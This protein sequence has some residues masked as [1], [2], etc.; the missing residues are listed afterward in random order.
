M[1]E[2]AEFQP[3]WKSPLFWIV[4]IIS[5]L[6]TAS[7][8]IVFGFRRPPKSGPETAPLAPSG[9]GYS[10]NLQNVDNLKLCSMIGQGKYGTVWKGMINEQPVAV[11]IFPAQHKQYFVNERNIY[12]VPFMDCFSLLSYFGK[13]LYRFVDIDVTGRD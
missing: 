6:V 5:A 3:V 10:S 13:L 11:K 7:L 4:L 12:S 9:P 8:L 1:P 2:I